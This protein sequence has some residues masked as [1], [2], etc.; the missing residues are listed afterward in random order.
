MR[1]SF[2]YGATKL[3]QVRVVS[4]SNQK[5]RHS[6]VS[7]V[8]VNGEKLKPTPRFWNS[9]Y[10]RYGFGKSLFRYFKHEEVFQR[11]SAVAPNDR[12][13]YCIERSP[14]GAGKLLAVTN[15]RRPLIKHDHL[16]EVLG[17]YDT[18]DI[19]YCDGVVQSHH[20]P[21]SGHHKLQIAGDNFSNRFVLRTPIDGYG[22]PNIHLAML[23]LICANGM[24]G[25]SKA[26]RSELVLGKG[27]DTVTFSL[28]RA[29]DGFDSDEGYS[30]LHQR[31]ES[32]SRSWASVAETSALYRLIA[33]LIGEKEIGNDGAALADSNTR[34]TGGSSI[35]QWF[36]QMTGDVSQL[37]GLANVDGLSTK[38]QRTLPVECK[39]YDLLNFATEVAT[40]HANP[41]GAVRLHAWFG[42][43]VSNEFDLEG[44][45]D[46]YSDFASFFVQD[47]PP[48]KRRQATLF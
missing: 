45:A 33:K 21:R 34:P 6:R 27:Q 5:D 14:R 47:A 11:I 44:T 18:S 8:L 2:E 35:L 13:R 41:R 24:I 38:R 30:A 4:E 16:M 28:R 42:E 1:A 10:Q 17:R 26:F 9:L 23:R 15:P 43:F 39:V 36:H 37:Y 32:A 12:M 3:G 7:S 46:H 29:L 19:E 31:F 20:V 22:L 48:K 40:H 25:M